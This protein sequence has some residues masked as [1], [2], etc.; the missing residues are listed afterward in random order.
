MHKTGTKIFV[1]ANRIVM[2]KAT[3]FFLQHCDI[4]YIQW[5]KALQTTT[6]S[7]KDRSNGQ[8]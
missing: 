2:V 6:E 1:N 8:K 7:E 3:T 4:T 5:V